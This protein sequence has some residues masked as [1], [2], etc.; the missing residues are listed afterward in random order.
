MASPSVGGGV[1]RLLQILQAEGS[2]I[3][4][5]G[6][7]VLRLMQQLD[8][9]RQAEHELRASEERYRLLLD[10]VPA[11]VWSLNPETQEFDCNGRWSE[12]TGISPAD[13]RG[14]GWVQTIHPDDRERSL[15]SRNQALAAGQAAE[16][17]H[18]LLRGSDGSYRWFLTR[19]IP[20]RNGEGR[21]LRWVGASIDIDDYKRAEEALQQSE[22]QFR[23]LVDGMPQ[24]AWTARPDGQIDYF[25]ERIRLYRGFVRSADGIWNW[26]RAVHPDDLERTE[27]RWIHARQ[28]SEADEV[29]HRLCMADGQWRWHLTR[30]MPVCDGQ[31][32]VQRWIGTGTDIEE[33]KRASA[34]LTATKRAAEEARAAAEHA[35]RA[36]DQFIAILSH[37]LRTPLAPVMATAQMLEMDERLIPD[38]RESVEMIRRNVELE[39]RL[40]DDLL[41]LTRISRGKLELHIET[42]DV[43]AK[44]GHVLQMVQEDAT[45]RQL[46]LIARPEAQHYHVQ[47]DA[48]RLQQVLWNLLVNSVKFTP[49]GGQITVRTENPRPDQITISVHDTG[50]GIAPDLLARLFNAFEQG[51]RGVTRQFGG[52]GLGLAISRSL[53]EMQ[54][55]TLAAHSE[56]PGR[57][58][59]FTVTLPVCLTCE[60]EAPRGRSPVST[61]QSSGR[62]LLVED[63]PDTAKMMARILRHLGFQVRTADSVAT[64]L[65]AAESEPFDLLISD[66]GL[67]DGTGIDLMRQL[68]ARKPTRAIAL[69][70]FG[71]EEDIARSREAGFAEHLTKPV[72]L[73]QLRAAIL[74]VLNGAR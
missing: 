57:G 38:Q 73:S 59:V 51:G 39:A 40:I 23:Q 1:E 12:Y 43:H 3:G 50:I 29:E 20:M 48:A 11:L 33:Y 15:Q 16:V 62:L 42:V 56:G 34:A 67:P 37:E 71:M 65:A 13:A 69:S 18:R 36:K 31:G 60:H 52:L 27:K 30:A 24:L 46:K 53:V 25:N 44:V 7:D 5:T 21:I 70:G 32:H 17:E 4:I 61:G 55:G 68:S 22:L 10:T 26:T 66:L 58:A 47:A 8:Q 35:S 9:L 2:R 54:R 63:H 72:E 45:A 19:A 49:A 41:D 14:L 64:A 28:H 6:G 74:R